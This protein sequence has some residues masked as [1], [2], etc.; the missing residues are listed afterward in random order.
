M[1]KTIIALLFLLTVY[2]FVSSEPFMTF[3]ETKHNFGFIRQG[4]E[5]SHVFYFT[6]TGTAP[7]LIQDAEVQCKCTSVDF[8]KQPILPNTK[9]SI[10]V[11]FDSKTAIDRQERTVTIRSNASNSPET[12]TF[13]AIVLK[14]KNKEND[15]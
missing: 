14:S 6:N 3:E 1:K 5:V 4:E 9:D 10:V 11:K 13:K 7:L 8:S 15:H 2:S 12:L